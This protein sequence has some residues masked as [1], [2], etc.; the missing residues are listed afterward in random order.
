MPDAASVLLQ[1]LQEQR[2]AVW[3]DFMADCIAK[4]WVVVLSA[5]TTYTAVNST[6]LLQ[7]VALS[8]IALL[9]TFGSVCTWTL[10]GAML[11][12]YLHTE[13]RRRGFNFAMAALLVASVIPVFWE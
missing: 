3:R 11:R 5:V 10:F 7:I 13:R 1:R 6:L 8:A 4:G 2:P 12:Q 9:I